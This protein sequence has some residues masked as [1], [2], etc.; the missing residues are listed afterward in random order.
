KVKVSITSD[1]GSTFHSESENPNQQQIEHLT[2]F[3]AIEKLP[4]NYQNVVILFYFQ[5]FS[6]KEIAT[7]VMYPEGTVKYNLHEARKTLKKLLGGAK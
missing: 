1:L 2:L 7:I 5:D 6:I 4:L 3:E